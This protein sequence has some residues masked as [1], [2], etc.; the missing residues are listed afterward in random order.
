MPGI[1]EEKEPALLQSD[2]LVRQKMLCDILFGACS[3]EEY[4]QVVGERIGS[5]SLCLLGL[6]PGRDKMATAS[7]IL[8]ALAGVSV[9]SNA[10][11]VA[12][13]PGRVAVV[14]GRSWQIGSKPGCEDLRKAIAAHVGFGVDLEAAEGFGAGELHAGY[15]HCEI[16][17]SERLR[18]TCAYMEPQS[19]A[20]TAKRVKPV[21][22]KAMDYIE[23]HFT[24]QITL[25]DVA[26]H[27]FASPFYISRLFRKELGI[28]FVDYL[29]KLRVENACRLLCETH[30]RILEVSERVGVQD[31]HY[32]AKLFKKHAGM[33][34][35]EYRAG[36]KL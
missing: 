15:L 21:L 17:L 5:F 7:E 29:G 13:A 33:S 23:K 4:E 11:V 27:A 24:E 31:A 25:Q 12:V 19:A 22:S 1:P 28:S 6:L 8:L 35:T 14:A 16:I 26:E 32:F 10:E 20:P 9:C 18:R 2:E 34:P 3:A 30:L 36:N